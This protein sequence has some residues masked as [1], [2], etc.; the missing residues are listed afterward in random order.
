MK[1]SNLNENNEKSLNSQDLYLIKMDKSLKEAES[2]A[3]TWGF[4]D[5]KWIKE[6][7]DHKKTFVFYL[8]ELLK[9]NDIKKHIED[10]FDLSILD[11]EEFDKLNL[12]IM[13]NLLNNVKD[14]LEW[15]NK[16]KS[17]LKFKEKTI[18][19][20]KS[21]DNSLK[22]EKFDWSKLSSILNVW[23]EINEDNFD[24]I[25]DTIFNYKLKR[26]KNIYDKIW[27]QKQNI[28]KNNIDLKISVDIILENI[29]EMIE[30][31]IEIEDNIIKDSLKKETEESE[32]LKEILQKNIN[33]FDDFI[34]W[35]KEKISKW[36]LEENVWDFKKEFCDKYDKILDIYLNEFRKMYEQKSTNQSK[37]KHDIES[38][39]KFYQNM[40]N[41]KFFRAIKKN[42]LLWDVYEFLLW[43]EKY[44]NLDANC[45]LAKE[46]EIYKSKTKPQL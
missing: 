6:F 9:N 20:K 15:L 13:S 28:E 30:E 38:L 12:N 24:T 8:K 1:I 23:F 44:L 26:L 39:W 34:K 37:I 45:M 22:N 43:I 31:K 2:I 27:D 5:E 3:I 17:N 33:F 41:E 7:K 19:T 42:Y 35:A 36:I 16:E 11:Q 21:I 14:Y 40:D 29:Q 10:C 4:R 25:F 32:K 46:L 18:E